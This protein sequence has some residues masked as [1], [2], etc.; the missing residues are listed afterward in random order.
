MKKNKKLKINLRQAIG[1]SLSSIFLLLLF[2]SLKW[3]DYQKIFILNEPIISGHK[4]L[5]EKA[6]K[7]IV[8]QLD[9]EIINKA[10]IVEIRKVLEKNPFVKAARVSRHFPNKI[11]IEIVERQ[12]LGIINIENQLMIDEEAV[13]LPGKNYSE[14]Y[15]IPVLSGFNSAKELY[16]EG[17]KTFSIKVKEAVSILRE[18]STKYKNL[19]ENIS[20]LTL[21]KDDEYVIILADRPTRVILGKDKISQKF[22][23][24][25]SFDKALG[26]RQL[27]DFRLIDMRY[28]KQLVARE[29]T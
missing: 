16:P 15:L 25:K 4:I 28:N 5:D 12:P 20:E 6:Y 14:D 17:E 19:Y 7:N 18:L 10:D 11:K 13:V 8:D 1:I 27:T 22:Y 21:N 3:A 9:Y 24:L 2:L 26:Q 23:I 29:W